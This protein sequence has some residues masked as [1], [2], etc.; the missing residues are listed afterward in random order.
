MANT[1][2]TRRSFVKAA[3]VAGLGLPIVTRSQEIVERGLFSDKDVPYACEQLL[4]LLNEERRSYGLKTLELDPLAC[5][6]R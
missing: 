1:H 2:L 6:H 5:D 3:A 4:K